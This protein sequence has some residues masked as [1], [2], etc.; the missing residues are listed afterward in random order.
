MKTTTLKIGNVAI[1]DTLPD[2]A[3]EISVGFV[4]AGAIASRD[5][6]PVHHNKSAANASGLANV[7][8]NILTDNG[9][10]GRFVTDWAGP[11]SMLK[12]VSIKLG[13]P[14]QPGETLKI[15]GSVA[16]IDTNSGM[17]DVKVTGKGNWGMHVDG[18]VRV[19]LPQ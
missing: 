6:T 3:I 8:P 9:L 11:E 17:V 2:L 16:A 4:V 15:T 19:K 13:A 7:F 5:F 1:G 14:V 18:T 12:R 10:V